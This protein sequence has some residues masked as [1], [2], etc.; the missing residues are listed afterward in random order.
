MRC[1]SKIAG[2]PIWSIP[3]GLIAVLTIVVAITVGGC[4]NNT[5]SDVRVRGSEQVDCLPNLKLLDQRGQPFSLAS[6]KGRPVLFD[7]FYTTCNLRRK[8]PVITRTEGA[9]YG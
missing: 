1:G 5:D 4:N 8:N 7:F 6:L 9:I 2:T 3:F